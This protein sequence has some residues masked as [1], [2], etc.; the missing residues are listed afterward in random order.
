MFK[1][2]L[3]VL[4]ILLIAISNTANAQVYRESFEIRCATKI[5]TT[6]IEDLVTAHYE[7]FLTNFST[8]TLVVNGLNILNK[9]NSLVYTVSD[10]SDINAI[11]AKI[12][13]PND[14]EPAKLYPGQSSVLYLDYNL[15]GIL[16][17]DSMYHQ[18]KIENLSNSQEYFEKTKLIP[19][20]PQDNLVMGNPL[21]SGPWAAVYHPAWKRGHRRVYYTINGKASIP[22]RFAVDFIKLDNNGKFA[23][24]NEDS[25]NNWF[26]YGANVLAVADGE[27]VKVLNDF[28]ESKLISQQPK[29][30]AEKEAGNF[31]V[32]K[33]KDDRFVFYEHLKP[34][35]ICVSTGQQVKQ[36]DVI[37]KIGF[38]GH[39]V[40]PHLHF[41]VADSDSPLGSEGVP[42]EFMQFELIGTYT[43]FSKFGKEVWVEDKK[44]LKK[45][46]P[47]SNSVI[48]F[49][50]KN[51]ITN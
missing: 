29:T 8:D 11:T 5:E 21:D 36:G 22:G 4:S 33:L 18:L 23:H 34:G 17:E 10:V 3:S 43:D 30:P 48:V 24:G 6:R 2:Q 7:I 49:N 50:A 15:A 51:T 13:N 9:S 45:N 40:G 42:F 41:H 20:S 38:T 27:I 46:G 12:G 31:V 25:I 28:P 39:T 16:P 37:G 32:I 26:G 44:I 47:S 14:K 19:V 35:S 1:Y